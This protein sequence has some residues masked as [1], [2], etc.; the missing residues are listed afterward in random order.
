MRDEHLDLDL[1][2]QYTD[3]KT[4][5]LRNLHNISDHVMQIIPK[6]FRGGLLDNEYYLLTAYFLPYLP[7]LSTN[8]I[9]WIFKAFA[10]LTS[11][12]IEGATRLLSI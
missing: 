3:P 11:T 4:G 7:C 6:A 9:T 5:V 10:I 8:S 12:S 2:F 1:D